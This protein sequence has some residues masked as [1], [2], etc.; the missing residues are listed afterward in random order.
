[1]SRK[2]TNRDQA[3]RGSAPRIERSE[4]LR[5]LAFVAALALFAALA[6]WLASSGDAGETKL[7]LVIRR[8]MTS[9]PSACYSVDGAYYDWVELQNVSTDAV[10]LM[11]WRLTNSGDIRDNACV[12][13]DITLDPEASLIVFC[14]ERPVDYAGDAVFSGFRLSADGVVLLL[15]DPWKSYTALVVPELR[16]GDVYQR[17]DLSGD[18]S[19]FSYREA[20]GMEEAFADATNSEYDPNSLMISEVMP[21]NGITLRD[22]DGDYS[23]WIE[24]YN[25]SDRAI[26][27]SGYALSDDDTNHMKWRFPARTIDPNA[28]L[29]VFASGKNRAPTEGELHAGFRLSREGETLHLYDQTGRVVSNL[30]YSSVAEDCSVSRATDGTV[31]ASLK[32]SPGGENT[33]LGAKRVASALWDNAQGIY[34]NEVFASGQ[35]ADWVELYNA[36]GGDIDLSGMGLSDDPSKPRKWRFPNGSRIGAGGYALIALIGAPEKANSAAQSNSAQPA[37]AQ[38][39]RDAAGGAVTA[40]YTAEIGLSSDEQICLS[41]R[42]GMLLDRIVICD[43]VSGVSIGRAGGYD[44]CRYFAQIT[45]GAANA[46]TSY[47][48]VEEKVSFSTPPGIVHEASIQLELTSSPG[49]NIYYT[50]DGSQPSTTSQRYTGPIT[51]KANTR[52]QALAQSNDK[53]P[54]QTAYATYIFGTHDLRFVSVTGDYSQLIGSSGTLNTGAKKEGYTVFV[55][56]YEPDGTQLVAQQCHL[57]LSGH[58]SRTTMAQ[59]AFRL[60]AR[61]ENGDT[62]FRAALFGQRDYQEYKSVVIRASGQDCFQTHMRD[63]ILSALAADTRVLYQETEPCVVYVNGEYWGLYNMRER[64]DSHSICQFEGWED[65][66]AVTL[67]EGSGSGAHGVQGSASGYKRMLSWVQ[68]NDMSKDESIEQLRQGMDIENYL[69]YVILEMYNC[70]QDLGNVR[71]YRSEEDKR[72]KWVLFDLDLSYQIDRNNVREW[73]NGKTVGSITPQ[74]STLFQGLMQNDAIKDAF[75][76]RFG[77]LLATTLSSE[78]VVGK[79]EARYNLIKDEMALNCKRW[80]WTTNTWNR[81]VKAMVKYANA[82]PAKLIGYIQEAFGLSDEQ[83][84]RYFGEALAKAA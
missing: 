63:S 65:P 77:Q 43:Q 62:R 40:N 56:M 2:K 54:S 25:G 51:I 52:I 58:Q 17:D 69:D 4:W 49:A 71:M 75:L 12:F 28:Y 70:N 59:K 8:V 57:T 34:I 3:W 38:D 18:Y 50:T 42:E 23:D 67:V 74:D 47:E 27:L 53:L 84:Q 60:T 6:T 81:Y 13:G 80:D 78:N 76:T 64:I 73:L 37:A 14:H 45:P 15:S 19:V 48:G 29:I 33:A 10:N 82:R 21:A 30:E 39:I 24:L 35:G 55:E 44:H 79:I 5:A 66:D 20:P 72:W 16:K 31:T 32:P 1:M 83:T 26:D 7:P 9:N 46:A 41:T 22:E 68:S 11:G 36:S 61:R